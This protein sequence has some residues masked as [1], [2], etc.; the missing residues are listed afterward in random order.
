ME[1]VPTIT[2][3][4]WSFSMVA[5]YCEF[6]QMMW[7]KFSL[8]SEE[9]HQLDWYRFPIEL[10]R[11]YLIFLL[12]AQQLAIVRGFGNIL[13]TRETFKRVRNSL[14][15][16]YQMGLISFYIDFHFVFTCQT[17]NAGFSYF[18]ALR[19]MNT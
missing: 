16:V 11:L 3:M 9:V 15:L 18:M 1:L 14:N 17:T 7:Q 13:C 2:E 12:D 8:F 4:V 6:S 19:S 10:Q 5:F